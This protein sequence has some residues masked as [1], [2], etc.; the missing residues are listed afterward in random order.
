MSDETSELLAARKQTMPSVPARQQR[1]PA[2]QAALLKANLP[3]LEASK[4]RGAAFGE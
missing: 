4:Y 2:D 3:Q 1:R